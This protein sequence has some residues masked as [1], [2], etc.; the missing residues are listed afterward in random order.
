[1]EQEI[2]KK[3]VK[4]FFEKLGAGQEIIIERKEEKMFFVSVK[5][6]EPRIF[7]G[8]RGEVLFLIQKLLVKI[9]KKKTRKEIFIDLDINDY[10]KKKINFLRELAQITADEVALHKKE[11]EL[12]PMPAYERR[13]IHLTLASRKDVFTE[14]KGEEPKRRVVIRPK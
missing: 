4:E 9:L 13:I 3:T 1:M 6:S 10:K 14:S 11:K 12:P 2:I 5:V 7:I 8:K